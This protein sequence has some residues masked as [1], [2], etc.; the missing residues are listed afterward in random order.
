[1]HSIGY[2]DGQSF[3]LTHLER[4]AIFQLASRWDDAGPIILI[5]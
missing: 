2:K 5:V 4:R 1:M 3:Y